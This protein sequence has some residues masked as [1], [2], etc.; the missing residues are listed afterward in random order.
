MIGRRMKQTGAQ[1]TLANA[2]RMAELC[3]L[4]YSDQ[5]IHYWNAA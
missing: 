5:W 1:W 4:N 2:N 3:S